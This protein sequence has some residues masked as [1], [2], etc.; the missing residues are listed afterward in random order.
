MSNPQAMAQSSSFG[1]SFAH[2][3]SH[4]AGVLSLVVEEQGRGLN[5]ALDEQNL[6]R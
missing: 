2:C 6:V 1:C 5:Q 4:T 3:F